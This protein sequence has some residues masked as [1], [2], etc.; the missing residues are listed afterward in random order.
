MAVPGGPGPVRDGR[1]KEGPSAAAGGRMDPG[2]QRQQPPSGGQSSR[3]RLRIAQVLS[4][5]ISGVGVPVGA[6]GPHFGI[7]ILQIFQRFSIAMLVSFMHFYSLGI[8]LKTSKNHVG[9][10]YI[11]QML[12]EFY[13]DTL[14]IVQFVRC[15]P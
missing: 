6:H 8:L 5:D 7:L 15:T 10:S 1:E 3:R 11:A 13:K 14:Y 4:A 2:G 12:C 9:T